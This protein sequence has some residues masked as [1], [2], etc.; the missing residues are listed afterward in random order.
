MIKA[1]INGIDVGVEPGTTILEAA[2]L[3]QVRIPILC[4]HQDLHATA[5]CGICVVK[6]KGAP[7]MI[8]A[9]S[10]PVTDGMDIVTQDPEIVAVRRS[11]LEMILAAHPNE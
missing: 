8:R 6:L 11:V 2:H 1:K 4:K 10:T 9:C 5:S 3:A 7:N